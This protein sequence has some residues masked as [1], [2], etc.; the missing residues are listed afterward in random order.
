MCSKTKSRNT[1]RL[2]NQKVFIVYLRGS[3]LVIGL[4]QESTSYFVAIVSLYALLVL[5]YAVIS[6][7]WSC[8]LRSARKYVYM[9]FWGGYRVTRVSENE[10]IA[11]QRIYSV[12]YY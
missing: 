7:P 9:R 1:P 2:W 5:R 11:I 3:L 4:A 6:R 8:L 10:D 12:L